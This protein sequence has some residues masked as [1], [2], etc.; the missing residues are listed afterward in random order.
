MELLLSSARLQLIQLLA[1][2]QPVFMQK[3]A[4]TPPVQFIDR[5]VNVPVTP[6]RQT[7]VIQKVQKT[8]EVPQIPFIDKFADAPASVQTE[9]K[10]RKLPLPTE[11]KTLSVNTASGDEE[12]DEG[13]TH[14]PVH[15]SLCDGDE[16]DTRSM[17]EHEGAIARQVSR[18]QGKMKLRC[19][20]SSRV[21]SVRSCGEVET[22]GKRAPKMKNVSRR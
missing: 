5:V 4:A 3:T 10:K 21:R 9:G 19:G 1:R 12:E 15:F 16:L 6:H 7:P 17:R 13:E 11:G 20:N 2:L 14:A 18:Q 8:V 22:T